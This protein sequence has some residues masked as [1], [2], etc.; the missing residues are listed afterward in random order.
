MALS[1]LAALQ[2]CGRR[3]KNHAGGLVSE[4]ASTTAAAIMENQP[5]FGIVTIAANAW[6]TDNTADYP[7]YYDISVNGITADHHRADVVFP[8]ASLE[9]ATGYGIS[10]LTETLANIIRIRAREV[11]SVDLTAQIWIVYGKEM[12]HAG[13]DE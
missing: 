11:P 8:S 7:A 6:K 9:K 12:Q 13:T 5:D 4:V 3:S 1:S 2:E 10:P